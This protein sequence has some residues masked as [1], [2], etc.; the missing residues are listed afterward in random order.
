[1]FGRYTIGLD[2]FKKYR[3][4]RKVDA[5]RVEPAPSEDVVQYPSVD[6]PIPSSNGLTNT[7]PKATQAAETIGSSPPAETQKRASPPITGRCR[8]NN[9]PSVSTTNL[10]GC[11]TPAL[12]KILR[13]TLALDQIRRLAVLQRQKRRARPSKSGAGRPGRHFH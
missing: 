12:D 10:A 6:A 8:R 3:G 11:L 1:M 2:P 5:R 9:W 4:D 7:N 13:R